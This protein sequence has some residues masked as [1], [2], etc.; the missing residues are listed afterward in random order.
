MS[1]ICFSGH[2]DVVSEM[3][4]G[5]E[6]LAIEILDDCAIDEARNNI[7]LRQR[8][9]RRMFAEFIGEPDYALF[10]SVSPGV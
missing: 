5:I 8:V 2:L 3:E 6:D 1:F 9:T 4:E 7:N 10:L